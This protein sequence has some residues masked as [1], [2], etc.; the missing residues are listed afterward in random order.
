MKEKN[1]QNIESSKL[2]S[3]KQLNVEEAQLLSLCVLLYSTSQDFSIARDRMWSV[4]EQQ[5][6][7]LTFGG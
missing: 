4:K 6:L 1:G 2:K 5:A 3:W 7:S